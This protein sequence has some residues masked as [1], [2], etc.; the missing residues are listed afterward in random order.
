MIRR[1]EKLEYSIAAVCIQSSRINIDME[2]LP[3]ES[4]PP[5]ETVWV[6]GAGHFGGQAVKQVR[7]MLPSARIVVVDVA[8]VQDITAA[9]DTVCC[10][11]VTWVV[12][13]LQ[14]ETSG[15]L[16]IP[17]LPLHVA[18]EWLHGV[19]TMEG[20]SCKQVDLP[21]SLLNSLPHPLRLHAWQ[22]AISHAD[23]L[24][25]ANCP[26]PDR[27]CSYTGEPRPLALYELLRTIDAGGFQKKII[28]SRQFAPGVGGFYPEDLWDLYE[29]AKEHSGFDLLVGTAC[30]CHGIIDG[31]RF[32]KNSI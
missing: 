32:S 27:L 26:E 17:A 12:D 5:L 22:A 31:V 20:V 24:C 19:M 1:V 6:L 15:T 10:D 7:K 9:D 13:H 8:Q 4:Y 25:P 11:A 2:T 3:P 14:P 29:Y 30:K 18:F 28:R 21:E 23:F 16:I